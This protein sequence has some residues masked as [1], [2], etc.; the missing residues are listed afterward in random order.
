MICMASASLQA[1]QQTTQIVIP[2]IEINSASINTYFPRLLELAMSKTLSTHGPYQIKIY[3][4][5][6][7]KGRFLREL[8]MNGV[9]SVMWNSNSPEREQALYP[10][11]VE[12]LKNLNNYRL[13]L[14]KN[15]NQLQFEKIQTVDNLK[16][17]K[18]GQGKDW[19]DAVVLQKNGFNI[20]TSAHYD[21]LFDML[22]AGRFDYFPRGIFEIWDEY[23]LHKHRQFMIEENIMLKYKN[24]V[25]FFTSKENKILAERIEVGLKIAIADGSFDELFYSY[26]GFREGEKILNERSWRVFELDN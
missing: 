24:P 22:E 16:T 10:I 26:K 8:E 23:E 2:P 19:N 6:L 17:L 7:T 14:I 1:N 3:G 12:L 11:K 5:S 4:H 21:L 9:I 25:Y 15:K 18:A 13:L 20:T